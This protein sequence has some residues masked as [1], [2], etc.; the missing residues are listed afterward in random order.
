MKEYFRK[1]LDSFKYAFRGIGFLIGDTP[2]AVIHV[3]MAIFAL[4]FG[5]YFKI[6]TWEW[7][8]IIIAI[9]LVIGL[10]AVNTSI[11]KMAD[12]ITTDHNEDIKKIKDIAAAAVLVAAIMALIV[13][14]VIF[15]PKIIN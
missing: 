1:R 3:V 11:E 5:L 14:V 4:L 12:I 7:I 8:S 10:E 9:G 2:N 6:A 13:G 15:V